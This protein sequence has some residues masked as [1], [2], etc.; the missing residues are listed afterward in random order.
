MMVNDE[1]LKKENG[2]ISEKRLEKC[3]KYGKVRI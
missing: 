1:Y 2:L 3:E